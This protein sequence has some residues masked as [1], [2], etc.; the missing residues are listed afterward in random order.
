MLA[1]SDANMGK[2]APQGAF[3]P[4]AGLHG[5]KILSS[6]SVGS[7]CTRRIST[8]RTCKPRLASPGAGF[9]TQPAP[10]PPC[11]LVRR[12]CRRKASCPP[13]CTSLVAS[14]AFCPMKLFQR[15]RGRSKR[16]D[17]GMCERV[18]LCLSLSLSLSLSLCVYF[19]EDGERER[20]RRRCDCNMHFLRRPPS[21]R[22]EC[23]PDDNKAPGECHFLFHE[24]R[25]F[26]A[27]SRSHRPGNS[28]FTFHDL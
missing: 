16:K 26:A 3:V 5:G 6:S 24:G 10:N 17:A 11:A 13:R 8:S 20:R 4:S 2:K 15:K 28:E 21:T 1:G 14:L 18:C 12:V 19:G 9:R 25:L 7:S 22:V 27:V 23:C